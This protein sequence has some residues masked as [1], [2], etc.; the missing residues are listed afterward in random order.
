MKN[1]VRKLLVGDRREAV[2]NLPFAMSKLEH[3]RR[4]GQVSTKV[5]TGSA[6]I[7]ITRSTHVDTVW[8][9]G[10]PNLWFYSW[11]D[12][13]L[14][15]CVHRK[16]KNHSTDFI[17]VNNS[18]SNLG[19][20]YGATQV[21]YLGHGR[22]LWVIAAKEESTTYRMECYVGSPVGSAHKVYEFYVD[23]LKPTTLVL[24]L[25]ANRIIIVTYRSD[26]GAYYPQFHVTTDGGDSWALRT[27][28]TSLGTADTTVFLR[29][30]VCETG[31]IV[32]PVWYADGEVELHKLVVSDDLFST[33]QILDS[34]G[35]SFRYQR[36]GIACVGGNTLIAAGPENPGAETS[37][38][39]RVSTDGDSSWAS[40]G[41]L[42][43]AAQYSEY[44]SQLGREDLIVVP[45]A[46]GIAAAL[47]YTDQ[48]RV[49]RLSSD[50]SMDVDVPVLYDGQLIS[51][52]IAIRNS[53]QAPGDVQLLTTCWD[54]TNYRLMYSES[55][56]PSWKRGSVISPYTAAPSYGGGN[57]R[58]ILI[59]GRRVPTQTQIAWSGGNG[60]Y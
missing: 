34:G 5:S 40:A 33:V 55:G 42:M 12:E 48:F 38:V 59:G 50:R 9:K 36:T 58:R 53:S 27:P 2:K 30:A 22:L 25:D 45:I 60:T 13:G 37:V 4:T 18:V 56:A 11:G 44:T 19:V 17:E 31:R 1:P 3:I 6:D 15:S 46:P 51:P 20:G 41:T 26:G 10:K 28:D 35:M 16:A 43:S 24:G 39:W 29:A 7:R 47:I 21:E 54:G 32:L 23:K 57:W 14:P 49:A 8:I 52:H